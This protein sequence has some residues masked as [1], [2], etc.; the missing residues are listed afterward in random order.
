[1]MAVA[2][3]PRDASRVY[4]VSRCGQ[5]FGTEDDG[6]TWTEYALPSGVE[7]VYSVAVI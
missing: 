7:D 2:Q 5:V 4:C 6:A 3:H 1:M